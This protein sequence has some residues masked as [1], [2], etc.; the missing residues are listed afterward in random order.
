[1][2]QE[3][4]FYPNYIDTSQ[5]I[6]L[7][8]EFYTQTYPL[9]L[10]VYDTYVENDHYQGKIYDFWV[11]TTT[12]SL[13]LSN[14]NQTIT[15]DT[16]GTDRLSD[17]ITN[18]RPIFIDWKADWIIT[19][20]G[21]ITLK[22]GVNDTY[23]NLISLDDSQNSSLNISINN[24]FMSFCELSYKRDFAISKFTIN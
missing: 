7:F 23:S 14:T 19:V 4:R 17:I 16:D 8:Q 9:K 20:T 18:S 11:G 15:I 3:Y 2:F 5:N 13:L 22:L 1:M 24:F 10:N 6:T 12:S 21:Q